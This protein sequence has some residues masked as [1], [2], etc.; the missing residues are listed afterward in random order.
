MNEIEEKWRLTRYRNTSFRRY[1]YIDTVLFV[2][3]HI[4]VAISENDLQYFK[5]NLSK[6]P[7]ELCIEINT[8]RNKIMECL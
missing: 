8:E 6:S 7:A 5:Y 1:F 4:L 3:N 2:E